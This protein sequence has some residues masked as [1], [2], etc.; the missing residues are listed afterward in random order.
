MSELPL[1]IADDTP[2]PGE[3]VLDLPDYQDEAPPENP[4]DMQ[5]SKQ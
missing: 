3:L 1:K 5:P 2:N 4:A